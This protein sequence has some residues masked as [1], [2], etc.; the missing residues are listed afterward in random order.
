[1]TR[2]GAIGV[3]FSGHRRTVTQWPGEPARH[4]RID[5][6]AAFLMMSSR[7]DWLHVPEPSECIELYPSAQLVEQVAAE[8]GASRTPQLPDVVATHDAVL[9]GLACKL[10][11]HLLG[12]TRLEE[13]DASVTVRFLLAHVLHRYGGVRLPRSPGGGLDRRR[14]ARVAELI[15]SRLHESLSIRTLAHA[16]A[17]SPFHFARS[18]RVSTGLTPHNYLRYARLQR[19]VALARNTELATGEIAHR[20]GYRNVAH[21]RHAFVRAFG[22]TPAALRAQLRC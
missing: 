21:F 18:F 9:W 2:S 20:V 6:G 15:E 22:I 8:M 5:P 13:L 1:M 3:S 14:L 10:R 7:L 17:L 11:A 16:A 19:A 12:L 4:M